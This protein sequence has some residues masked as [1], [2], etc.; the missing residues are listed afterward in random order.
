MC[1]YIRSQADREK[2]LF[3]LSK[4]GKFKQS[5]GYNL[6]NRFQKYENEVFAFAFKL[7]VTR[8]YA[9][10]IDNLIISIS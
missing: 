2:P 7:D 8:T 5:V 9:V 3:Q 4:H 1:E 10:G 6:L